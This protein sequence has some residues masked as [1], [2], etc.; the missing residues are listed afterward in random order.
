MLTNLCL[1]S[2]PWSVAHRTPTKVNNYAYIV[3]QFL[4]AAM[5][6][7]FGLKPVRNSRM[8]L[9]NV[10][11]WTDTIKDWKKLLKPDK[12]KTIIIETIRD[13]CEKK[14]IIVYG[15]VIMPNH[16]HLIWEMK[17][18]NGKEMPHASFNKVTA[19]LIINDL[20][21]HHVAVLSHF[22]VS[23]KERIY[24]VWKRDPL[25]ILMDG[26]NKME[27]KL[28]Y[29]HDNPLNERWNLADRPEDYFWSS[30]RFY[31]TGE[32]DFKFLTHYA[33]RF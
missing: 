23:E 22:R 27:Q 12:Y 18:C 19:H 29:I 8:D 13:L 14:L 5:E 7:E 17:A 3:I 30:A 10:Y 26:K 20:E 24:R 6:N 32:D 16:L 15:F 28:D 11:F 21:E 9:D 2:L 1:T 33:D 31:L 4:I 25:A